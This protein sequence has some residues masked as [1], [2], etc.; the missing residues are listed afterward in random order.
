MDKWYDSVDTIYDHLKVGGNRHAQMLYAL[1]YDDE[2]A[3]YF[4]RSQKIYYHFTLF[5][6]E[7]PVGEVME[8]VIE[9]LLDCEVDS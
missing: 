4:S 9:N 5:E 3:E 8:E 7:Q 6:N 2:N 1:E